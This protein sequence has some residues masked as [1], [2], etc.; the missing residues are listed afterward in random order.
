[1][2]FSQIYLVWTLLI[3]NLLSWVINLNETEIFNEYCEDK[4]FYQWAFRTVSGIKSATAGG[5]LIPTL[6]HFETRNLKL[7]TNLLAGVGSALRPPKTTQFLASEKTV[8]EF[9]RCPVIYQ[10]TE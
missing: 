5:G 6:P 10:F 3:I 1:M 7:E 8:L 2:W 4:R 9:G